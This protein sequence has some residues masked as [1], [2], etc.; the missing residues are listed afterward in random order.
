ML[1]EVQGEG[2]DLALKLKYTDTGAGAYPALL[3]SYQIVCSKGLA[4]EP[5]AVLTDFLGYFATVEVQA[6]LEELGYAPLP[7]DLQSK[8]AAAVESIQ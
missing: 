1:A 5:T 7:A 6:G 2:N 3:V 4:A 8:V